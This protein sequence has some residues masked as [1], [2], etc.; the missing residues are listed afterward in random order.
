MADHMT[1][2]QYG[3]TERIVRRCDECKACVSEN[4]R[5][6][7][8]S[9][10]DVYCAHPSLPDRKRIGD[11]T[12]YTPDWCPVLAARLSALPAQGDGWISVE[13]RLPT[14]RREYQIYYAQYGTQQVSEFIPY[15]S[16][17]SF[18]HGDPTHWR[19]CLP[20]PAPKAN[21]HG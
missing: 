16:P 10:H 17:P 13:D 19:E 6:Q 4:Y 7:S 3:P 5:C 2:E 18:W 1:A 9:G 20:P 15:E 21:D 8:D 12:W 11:T 14:E